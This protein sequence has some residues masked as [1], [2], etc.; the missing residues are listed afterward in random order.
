MADVYNTCNFG[1]F[2]K[3][4]RWLASQEQACQ[5]CRFGGGWF[6]W[7]D[8]PVRDCCIEKNVDFCYQ[9]NEFPCRKLQEAPDKE[10]KKHNRRKQPDQN[11]RNWTSHATTQEEIRIVATTWTVRLAPQNLSLLLGRTRVDVSYQKVYDRQVCYLY[12]PIS[13]SMRWLCCQIKRS[14]R[15]Q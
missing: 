3:G 6:W 15:S 2:L 13:Q 14:L 11:R 5:G 4:L 10:L 9:C 7:P 12:R 1:E 8:C